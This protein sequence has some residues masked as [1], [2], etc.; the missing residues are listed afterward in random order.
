M[1]R[2]STTQS[3]EVVWISKIMIPHWMECLAY[4]VFYSY[5]ISIAKTLFQA[6]SE[7][8]GKCACECNFWYCQNDSTKYFQECSKWI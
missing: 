8:D 5:A 6:L 7:V 3:I 1:K 4:G 2:E